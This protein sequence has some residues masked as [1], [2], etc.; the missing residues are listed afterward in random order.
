M[1]I[2]KEDLNTGV[3]DGIKTFLMDNLI[4]NIKTVPCQRT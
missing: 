3:S 4:K 2:K 1:I